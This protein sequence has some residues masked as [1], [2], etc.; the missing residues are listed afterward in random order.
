[1]II[2][3]SKGDKDLDIIMTLAHFSIK[4]ELIAME[5]LKLLDI[6]AREITIP[7]CSV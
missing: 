3:F 4:I 1:M 6:H 7:D 5:D 2:G